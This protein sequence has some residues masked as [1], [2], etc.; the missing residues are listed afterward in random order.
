MSLW[1]RLSPRLKQK[2]G[3][4]PDLT[5]CLEDLAK[6]GVEEKYSNRQLETVFEAGQRSV[7]KYGPLGG[8]KI[9]KEW[10]SYLEWFYAGHINLD[11]DYL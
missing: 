9:K 1:N 5:E 8:K 6:L 10:P 7:I 11:D 4:G 2:L 3:A